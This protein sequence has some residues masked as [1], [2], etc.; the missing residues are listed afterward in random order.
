MTDDRLLN[1][2]SP[3][4]DE[5]KEEHQRHHRSLLIFMR[6][7]GVR[8]SEGAVGEIFARAVAKLADDKFPAVEGEDE[9]GRYLI[10][11]AR[12]V[13]REYLKRQQTHES[14]EGRDNKGTLPPVPAAGEDA[15]QWV[16]NAELRTHIRACFR[17]CMNGLKREDS[18]ML[19]EYYRG[20][21]GS[22]ITLRKELAKRLGITMNAL[23]LRVRD[24][25]KALRL[26][27][28]PCLTMKGIKLDDLKSL[29]Y[30]LLD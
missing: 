22:Q 1:W 6:R 28:E 2:Y 12:N 17:R 11:Y 8:D 14:F 29:D 23:T 18:E 20:E 26:C 7:R 15:H 25:R 16:E 3:D 10:G 13:C 21:E 5:A 27:V 9:R 24:R 30:K 19:L 4:P